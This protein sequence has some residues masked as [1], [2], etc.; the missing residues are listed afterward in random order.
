LGVFSGVGFGANFSFAHVAGN[1]DT[2]GCDGS[3]GRSTTRCIIWRYLCAKK[4]IHA[5][6]IIVLKMNLQ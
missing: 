4:G 5:D 3:Y 2:L 6:F 1:P